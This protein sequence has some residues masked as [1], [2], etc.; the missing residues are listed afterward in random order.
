M[1]VH[2]TNPLDRGSDILLSISD[3]QLQRVV[4]VS[5]DLS[6]NNT[7]HIFKSSSEANNFLKTKLKEFLAV[8]YYGEKND[9]SFNDLLENVHQSF[10]KIQLIIITDTPKEAESNPL[11]KY[12]YIHLFSKDQFLKDFSKIMSVNLGLNISQSD[13]H[14]IKVELDTLKFVDGLQKDVFIKSAANGNY[15]ALFRR[16]SALEKDEIEIYKRKGLTHVYIEKEV[17]KEL[18]P[19][20]ESQR[21]FF[22]SYSGFKFV[23][24]TS[25]DPLDKRFERKILRFQDEIL[26]DGE[27]QTQIE[28]AISKTVEYLQKKPKASQFLK[29]MSLMKSKEKYLTEHMLLLSFVTSSWAHKLG[30]HSQGTKDKLI[31]AAIIHDITLAGHPHLA[32]ITGLQD[33][34]AKKKDLSEKEQELYLNHPEEAANLISKYF[35][36]AP[37][38]TADIILQHHEKADGSGFPKKL[39]ISKL[40][41]LTMLFMLAHDFVEN[42][43]H[44]EDYSVKIFLT[45][46]QEK[47][48]QQNFRKM[49]KVIGGTG[50]SDGNYT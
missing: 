7:V 11:K 48:T 29:H 35:Q 12:P 27:F 18:L 5:F 1:A 41:P 4:K 16:G 21:A 31:F 13:E 50:T 20:I 10:P 8:F 3:A 39:T 24:R 38:D 15:S 46:A 44:R 36:E 30:W 6:C 9:Y 19:Q 34:K 14:Y 42:F 33:F 49:L 28:G 47:F 23:L 2:E 25:E 22:A 45:E 26:L 43:L 40:S 32:E 37:K 17:I